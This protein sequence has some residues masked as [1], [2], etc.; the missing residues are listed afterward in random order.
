M[1]STDVRRQCN[2]PESASQLCAHGQQ[3]RKAFLHEKAIVLF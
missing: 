2:K 1:T 3:C